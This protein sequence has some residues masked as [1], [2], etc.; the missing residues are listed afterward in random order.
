MAHGQTAVIVD[1]FDDP[2]VP[3]DAYRTTFVRSMLMVPIGRVDPIAAVG[4]YWSEFG[5]ATDNEIALLEALA[6]AASVALENERLM[7]RMER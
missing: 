6:R 7:R 4:A 3:Q 1:I 5:R 2:R